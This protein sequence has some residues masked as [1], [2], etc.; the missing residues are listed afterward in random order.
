MKNPESFVISGG[1]ATLYF[2]LETGTRQGDAIS[3][4]LWK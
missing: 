4:Y 3:A 2:G 1:K